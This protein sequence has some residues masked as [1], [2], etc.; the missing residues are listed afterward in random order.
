MTKLHQILALEKTRK[1]QAK[2]QGDEAYHQ[3]QRHPLSEG[4]RETYEPHTEDDVPIEPKF[5]KVQA[6]AADL[7][8]AY[9]ASQAPA[10][11]IQATKDAANTGARADVKIGTTV[12]LPSVPVTTLISLEKWLTDVRTVIAHAPVLSPAFDWRMNDTTGLHE[13]EPAQTVRTKKVQKHN[14]VVPASDKFPA[15]VA[16]D[17]VDVAA[18]T[19]TKTKMSGALEETRRAQLLERATQLLEAVKAAREEANGADVTDV[20]IADTLFTWLKAGA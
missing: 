16:V 9:L 15:Q 10:W 12:L 20:K 17:S 3:L 5:Q 14:V 4:L 2:A 18:G 6:R 1:N 7:I 8:D 13:T 11:D 19:W